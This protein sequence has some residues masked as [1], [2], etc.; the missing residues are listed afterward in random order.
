LT[1]YLA[2]TLNS[3]DSR[4]RLFD[5][6]KPLVPL[7]EFDCGGGIWRVK[8]HATN[9]ER[10]LVAAMHDGF[11]IVDFAGLGEGSVDAG[12]KLHA[13]F[14]GHESLA[15]GVDWSGGPNAQGQDVVASCSFYDHLLHVWAA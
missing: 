4:L 10:V 14:D 13:R 5:R 7:T 15:Y 3:Y 6:R 11:K 1:L 9:P 12:G 8:W 2:H